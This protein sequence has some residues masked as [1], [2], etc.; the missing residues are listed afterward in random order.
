MTVC[1]VISLLKTLYDIYMYTRVYDI[2][3]YGPGQP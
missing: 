3:M 1:M 2:D